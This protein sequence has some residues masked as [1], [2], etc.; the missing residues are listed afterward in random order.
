MSDTY[1]CSN[2]LFPFE[3]V[4]K[5]SEVIIFGAGMLGKQY[6]LQLKETGY[7]RISHIVDR[8][9]KNMRWDIFDIESPD[10]ISNTSNEVIVVAVSNKYYQMEVLRKLQ[11]L[12]VDRSRIVC[13]LHSVPEQRKRVIHEVR[14]ESAL[15]AVSVYGADFISYLRELN[16]L[17]KIRKMKGEQLVRVGNAAD[18]GYIMP[19]KCLASGENQIA[20]SFGICDDVSWDMDMAEHGYDVYMYDHTIPGLVSAHEKF[21]FFK[22]GIASDDKEN[23]S[24]ETLEYFLKQNGH[25]QKGHMILKMDVEGAEYGFVRMTN[26]DTLSKFDCIV[27]EVHDLLDGNKAKEILEFFTKIN[28][29]HEL[30]HVHANNYNDVL[31]IGNDAYAN[32]L[33]L[34]YV[35]KGRYETVENEDINLPI[36]VDH[37]CWTAREEI[38]LGKWNKRKL[39]QP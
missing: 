35:Q 26:A 31:W 19:K 21:H 7:C 28:T 10:I 22:K 32:V 30:V 15:E 25:A 8:N 16:A 20:Y 23:D 3:K 18:G 13:Q 24:L 12:K 1:I 38:C 37:P 29:T 4:E 11:E 17:L 14:L 39:K 9:W 33:E 36:A 6:A 34:T 27:F 2:D 5:G